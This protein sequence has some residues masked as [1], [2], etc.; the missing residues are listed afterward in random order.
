VRSRNEQRKHA[1]L[2]RKQDSAVSEDP[3]AVERP[4]QIPEKAHPAA[5]PVVQIRVDE[6][7]E[8]TKLGNA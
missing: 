7:D 5:A 2:D 8:I 6:D 4:L 3:S 1:D